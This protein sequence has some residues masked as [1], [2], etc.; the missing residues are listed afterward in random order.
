MMGEQQQQRST[1]APA[2]EPTRAAAS[3]RSSLCCCCPHLRSVCDLCCFI[4][5]YLAHIS[6]VLAHPLLVDEHLTERER[7]E[8]N[9]E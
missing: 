4:P 8:R 9:K 6:F 1:P 7:T 2:A 3:G 5:E